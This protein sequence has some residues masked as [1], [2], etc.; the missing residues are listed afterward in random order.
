MIILAFLGLAA[1]RPQK[2]EDEV[3]IIKSEN[4]NSGDGTFNW[5]YELSD[6]SK[7]EQSGYIKP[8][9]DPE[10]AIQVMQG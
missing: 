8:S 6:G 10:N 9:D 4:E 5:A 1:A 2:A 3:T 7:Q